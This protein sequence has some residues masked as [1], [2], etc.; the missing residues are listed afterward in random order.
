MSKDKGKFGDIEISK[1]TKELLGAMAATDAKLAEL[2][3]RAAE[4]KAKYKE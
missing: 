3:E 4:I 1:L 2:K